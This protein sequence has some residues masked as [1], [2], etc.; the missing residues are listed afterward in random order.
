MYENSVGLQEIL[1]LTVMYQNFVILEQKQN[2]QSTCITLFADCTLSIIRR[3][4]VSINT[5]KTSLT[6]FQCNVA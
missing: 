5:M 6:E 3:T 2:I 1:I 4:S